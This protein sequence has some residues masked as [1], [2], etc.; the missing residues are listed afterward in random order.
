MAIPV[1]VGVV[2]EASRCGAGSPHVETRQR[3]KP[4]NPSSTATAATCT[5][6]V[7]LRSS[8]DSS[9]RGPH[10]TNSIPLCNN[11][12]QNVQEEDTATSEMVVPFSPDLHGAHAALRDPHPPHDG[13]HAR[14][15]RPLDGI[16]VVRPDHAGPNHRQ[17]GVSAILLCAQ[18]QRLQ[19]LLRQKRLGMGH[20]YTLHVHDDVPRRDGRTDAARLPSLD[21]R[22]G[23]VVHCHAVVLWPA[24]D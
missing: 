19:R 23:M 16:H 24:A 13:Q 21:G 8:C 5:F 10:T 17:D 11:G 22:H 15:S 14:P 1:G 2:A 7:P 4:R 3:H 18:E 12:T 9:Q 6:N 20:L